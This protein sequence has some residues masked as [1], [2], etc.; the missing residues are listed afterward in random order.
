MM[1]NFAEN[2]FGR[3]GIL[4]DDPGCAS[5]SDLSNESTQTKQYIQKACAYGLM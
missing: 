2:V 1:V 5:F 3:T 4:V